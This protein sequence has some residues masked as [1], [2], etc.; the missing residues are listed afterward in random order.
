MTVPT[1]EREAHTA[2][3]AMARGREDSER[4][5]RCHNTFTGWR[6]EGADLATFV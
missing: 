5:V 1:A 6:A 4:R 2:S 3:W